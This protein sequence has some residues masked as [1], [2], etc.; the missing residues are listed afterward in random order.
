MILL[1]S[2]LTIIDT[3]DQQEF[4]SFLSMEILTASLGHHK[5][6]ISNFCFILQFPSFVLYTFQ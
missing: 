1:S 5:V 6:F 4:T 2:L 3:V